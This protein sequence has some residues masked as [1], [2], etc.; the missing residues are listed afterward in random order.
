MN[1]NTRTISP[2]RC[3]LD[4]LR[5]ILANADRAGILGV[6]ALRIPHIHEINVNYG[7][8]V[9]DAV[10]HEVQARIA[11]VIRESDILAPIEDAGFALILPGLLGSAQAELAASKIIQACK[12]RFLVAG[13]DITVQVSVGIALSPRDAHD[14][15]GLLRCAELALEPATDNPAGYSVYCPALENRTKTIHSYVLE[16]A[17]HEALDRDEIYLC[18]QPKIDLRTGQL[19]GAEALARWTR[20]NGEAVLPD[21]F[22]PIAERSR[23]I[24]PITL[25][26]LNAALR[27][28]GDY[29]TRFP[30]FSVAVNL[31]PIAL[32]DPDIFDFVSQSASIWCIDKSQLTLE[33]TEGALMEDPEAAIAILDKFHNDSIRLSIDDFGTGYSSLSQLGRL[34]VGELKIDKSFVLG[35]IHSERN[36][37]IVRSIIDLAHN[38]DMTVVAEGIEDAATLQFL[39]EL[40]CDY[41]QGY[42]IGR[43]MRIEVFE[44]WALD[45][46]GRTAPFASVAR[47]NSV[48]LPSP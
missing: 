19:S 8:D 18:L 5:G 48:L 1:A 29:F 39:A 30:D 21:V 41:G 40:G 24:V 42:Y 45:L 14:A 3:L 23:L 38:F 10:V 37:K 32:N 34:S 15:A 11:A 47:A 26:T 28:C 25:W 43:P 35:V 9:S 4:E 2:R 36:A 22:I 33:I 31:S 6:L 12:C 13:H 20:A 46:D 44:R 7:Y 27:A 17:L 16:R